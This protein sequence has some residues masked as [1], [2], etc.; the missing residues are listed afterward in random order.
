M[1]S[2]QVSNADGLEQATA[3]ISLLTLHSTVVQ[4]NNIPALSKWRLRIDMKQFT[5]LNNLNGYGVERTC[6]GISSCGSANSNARKA[7][8]SSYT[9]TNTQSCFVIFRFMAR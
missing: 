3:Y 8:R 4:N 6:F 2:L 1:P 7:V 5:F 9:A